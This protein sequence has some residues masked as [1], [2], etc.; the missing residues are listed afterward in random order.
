MIAVE[1][2]ESMRAALAEEL[3][4]VSVIGGSAES[5]PLANA[6][7]DSIVVG[8]AFHWFDL[9][10]ALPE[11]HRVL[12]SGG[13]LGVIWNDLDTTVDWVAN[14]NAIIAVARTGT[15]HPSISGSAKLGESFGPRRRHRFAHAHLHDRA[16]LLDRVA[17]MSF[18]AVQPDA[19]RAHIL[20][21]VEAL[22][23]GHPK[24]TGR[25]TFRLPYVTHAWWA[26]RIDRDPASA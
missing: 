24:L 15:P 17:S 9:P 1:P 5:L 2:L 18:V 4:T 3:P 22:V 23:A 14:L 8:Q 21:D 10:R 7:A 11:F 19:V 6:S 16:S 20:A 13:R 25:H 12:R 26:E